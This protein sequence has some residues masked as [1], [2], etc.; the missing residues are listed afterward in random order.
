MLPDRQRLVALKSWFND[1]IYFLF[2]TVRVPVFC[3]S[4]NRT[5]NR[6]QTPVRSVNRVPVHETS[7]HVAACGPIGTKFGTRMEINLEIV[8]GEIKITPCNLG[9]MW[10]GGFRGQ[11][12]TNLE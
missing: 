4:E 5:E 11:K 8:M 3:L 1:V 9:G 6:F 12:I 7:I 10:G 2:D